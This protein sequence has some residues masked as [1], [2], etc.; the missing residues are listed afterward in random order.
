MGLYWIGKDNMLTSYLEVSERNDE[1]QCTLGK[2]FPA[3]FLVLA[4]AL[5]EIRCTW[6]LQ[7]DIEVSR[8]T[9]QKKRNGLKTCCH[10]MW[11]RRLFRG[12]DRDR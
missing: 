11:P 4:T 7:G 1:K 3:C 2:C 10:P 9:R 8:D 5:E 6:L 12:S